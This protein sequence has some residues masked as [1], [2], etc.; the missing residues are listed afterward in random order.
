M[1]N[2]IFIISGPAGSG[3]NTVAEKLLSEFSNAQRVV[4]TTSRLPREGEKNGIDY[5]FISSEEFEKGIEN[6]DFYEYA[7]VHG[8]YYGTSKKSV[9]KAFEQGKD[10]VLIIDVQGAQT[11]KKI[12]EENPDIGRL[13]KSVFIS[14]DSMDE[15]RKR[16]EFRGSESVEE[17]ETRLKTAEKEMQCSHMFDETIHSKTREQDYAS[18]REIYLR[19]KA[20]F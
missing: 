19:A 16:M 13:V 5:H 6:G 14:V 8:R 15:L 4:T 7:K 12:G 11:W 9:L 17:M 1:A 18:F 2:R 20:E 3:K 10:L